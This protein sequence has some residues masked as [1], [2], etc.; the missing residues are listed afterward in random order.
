MS[1]SIDERIVE[2]RFQ[3][4][5]FERGI[6]Q[7]TESL[8]N[9]KDSLNF[10]DS[11]AGT[12]K[13]GQAF[14]DLA[15]VNVPAL[16]S[17]LE[18]AGKGFSAL[19]TMAVSSLATIASRVTDAAMNVAKGL[20]IDQI[21]AGFSKYE[22]TIR[23]TK[24]IMAATGKEAEE[25]GQKLQKLT[26]FTDE[27]S[28]NMSDM[29]DNI[30]KFTSAG[31]DLD[32]SVDSMMGIANWAAV[33]GQNA[34][35]ASRAMY[36]MSQAIG[37]GK[38]QLID[39]RS[40]ENAS[41]NTQEFMQTAIDTAVELGKLKKVNDKVMTSDKKLAVTT[42]SFSETLKKGWFTTDVM[43]ATLRK[44]S[45]YTNEVYELCQKEGISASEA[46]D[47]L[48]DSTD[49][50]GKKSFEAGQQSRTFA[51]SIDATKDAVSTQWMQT[52]EYIFGN[53]DEAVALWTKVTDILWKVF[54][55]GGEVRNELLEIWHDDGGRASL[56]NAFS[57]LYDI[58]SAV[59]D[60]ADRAFKDIIPPITGERLIELT[61]GFE[62]FT[63]RVKT[64][65]GFVDDFKEAVDDAIDAIT[66]ADAGISE[67]GALSTSAK[68]DVEKAQEI[69]KTMPEWM[70][71]WASKETG[72][73]LPV[74][75]GWQESVN[76]DKW[77]EYQAAKLGIPVDLIK[78]QYEAY[79]KLNSTAKNRL[80][81]GKD[82]SWADGKTW[83]E[84]YTKAWNEY[85]DAAEA[86]EAAIN[87][88]VEA[89]NAAAESLEK[90]GDAAE[91]SS[92]SAYKSLTIYEKLTKIVHGFAAAV[93]IVKTT[94][95]RLANGVLKLL[96]ALKPLGDVFTDILA[97]IGDWLVKQDEAVKKSDKLTRIIDGAVSFFKPLI[98]DLADAIRFL[99][100]SFKGIRGAVKASGLLD[101][102]GQKI[103]VVW[104]AVKEFALEIRNS[105]GWGIADFIGEFANR[106]V[107]A[108]KSFFTID[109]SEFAGLKEKLLKRL[110]PLFDVGD[111]LKTLI[112]FNKDSDE[113]DTVSGADG[114]VTYL[115]RIKNFFSNLLSPIVNF[116]STDTS[117]LDTLE[118]KLGKRFEALG[119]IGKWLSEFITGDTWK[120]IKEGF[121]SAIQE[122][123]GFFKTLNFPKSKESESDLLTK[124]VD[125]LIP[126][127][128]AEEDIESV[129]EADEGAF[130]LSSALDNAGSFFEALGKSILGILKRLADFV[131]PA[132]QSALE[133]G[134]NIIKLLKGFI[135]AKALL[136]MASAANNISKTVK[137]LA[138]VKKAENTDSIGTTFLKIAG[139]L[140]IVAGTIALLALIPND[141][142]V[143]GG[144]VAV[145]IAAALLGIS[146]AFGALSNKFDG[147]SSAGDQFIKMASALIIVAAAIMALALIP[148]NMYGEAL[149]KMGLVFIWL[150]G[151]S[152]LLKK[153][154]GGTLSETNGL[155]GLAL[156]IL[157]LAGAIIVLGSI[158]W[159][160]AIRG[161]A[162]LGLILI[163]LVTTIHFI[164][165]SNL[166][167]SGWVFIGLAA[168]ILMLVGAVVILGGMDLISL[169]KGVVA[170]GGIFVGLGACFKLMSKT[171]MT[172]ALPSI[173]AMAAV[174][175]LFT[176]S[177]KQIK[178]VPWTTIAAFSAGM[179]AICL[180]F[181]GAITIL[182]GIPFTAGIKAAGLLA[183]FI[184]AISAAFAVGLNL[185]ASS[186]SD[187]I[188]KLSSALEL[189]GGMI[190]GF[191]SAI[192]G[193]SSERVIELKSIFDVLV[194][195][196][197]SIP[198]SSNGTNIIAFSGYLGQLG[199]ALN[200][201]IANS[202]DATI[203]SVSAR[204][205][206]L[207][208]LIGVLT[209]ISSSDFSNVGT[210]SSQLTTLGG[211]LKIFA[212][213]DSGLSGKEA[214]TR[215]EDA[216]ALLST[217]IENLPDDLGSTISS[218]P[219]ESTL[220]TFSAQ[221]VALGG[222]LLD[223]SNSVSDVN[224]DK[225]DN[226][227][228]SLGLLNELDNNLK[229][230]G[231]VIEQ[232][233]GISSL[234]T[235]STSVAD[236]GG[237]LA[238]FA[239]ETKDIDGN[240]VKNA[241][242]SLSMLNELD[243]GLT[244]H[245]G[246]L[247]FF[248]GKASLSTFS[249]D[250]NA[251]GEGLRNFS[252]KT[253]DIDAAKVTAAANALSILGTVDS[254][255]TEHG[256]LK[257]L[258][259]GDQTL[260]DLGGSLD[261]VG[262]GL[263][264]FCTALKDV[265]NTDV[266]EKA[267]LIL[268]DLAI[269][270]T[271]LNTASSIYNLKAFADS[272]HKSNTEGIGIQLKEFAS[273]LVGFNSENVTGAVD[274]L[275]SLSSIDSNSLVALGKTF[276]DG[277]ISSSTM[278]DIKTGISTL[279]S[280]MVSE[281][282][283]YYDEFYSAGDYLA[284]G[285]AIG[286]SANAWRV[287]N[288]AA[289][290]ARK[291]VTA[292]RNTLDINSPSRVGE[293]I[294]MYWDMGVA[295]GMANYSALIEDAAKESSETAVR[296]AAGIVA[297]VSSVMAQDLDSAPTITPVLDMSNVQAGLTG[298]DGM[299]GARTLNVSGVN[300]TGLLSR[301]N[302]AVPNQNGSDYGTIVNAIMSVN[303][304]INELGE[305]LSKMQV[306]LNSGALVGQIAG[307][308]DRTL[309]ERTM[310]KGR[311][312]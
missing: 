14:D 92:E 200:L 199:S 78:K 26:W 7:S 189:T 101:I 41:M 237:G 249:T 165:S 252:N 40:I 216:T 288:A 274:V 287:V 156:G 82:R 94:L 36:N 240:K 263:A 232:I 102:L 220:S 210:F 126:K 211:A 203:E 266:A 104:N 194:G 124:F 96:P 142:L 134:T 238:T 54:A 52:F 298:F 310:L 214:A 306:V 197:A 226:A 184:V 272:L 185:V 139:A 293:E 109:T 292:T 223:F 294:G 278:T 62:A 231:G 10:D 307:D 28:Y 64:A 116:F 49:T 38:M 166:G 68:A 35:S 71:K 80:R 17:A 100:E 147:M 247:E 46:M 76:F 44:Y 204:V 193:V 208:D 91:D 119:L 33:S 255:L 90:T 172:K 235:F 264:S 113:L 129:E 150:A 153:V 308:M 187:A 303:G 29:T 213:A 245:G 174:M 270:D 88:T 48:S 43:L 97:E 190:S 284:A 149:I 9:L 281:I 244:L 271:N 95:G 51:D 81:E 6:K 112:G 164:E 23:S 296:S 73:N 103:S 243:S 257:G 110:E 260:G 53:I 16:N 118:E 195:I 144:F 50:L 179:S 133:I 302:E 61:K 160:V 248:T 171:N 30:A 202:A 39:W 299:F 127:A 178:D 159:E 286:I 282:K 130:S 207:E 37:A 15:A 206:S 2:M 56:L 234:D 285:I 58:I 111:W 305:R 57:N 31:V 106:F 25:V 75:R 219:A 311:G 55:S 277:I 169:T 70:K 251:V 265:T 218:I 67:D 125:F 312:N 227:I 85:W 157:I 246:I 146:T 225:V 279:L 177:I 105:G 8:K 4:D 69:Y 22:T 148:W 131:I 155:T 122:I 289:Y 27:T 117:E 239:D 167:K 135:L 123:K 107:E 66:G 198:A 42:S 300:T 11:A 175:V 259:M 3:N 183:I 280:S 87:G 83:S 192:D 152:A 236:L 267:A 276:K 24:T 283:G 74:I 121:S 188:V 228:E 136:S 1:Q 224:Q 145:C 137:T 132:M 84:G 173:L 229:N 89:A 301:A 60:I 108:I 273:D 65:L 115:D 128:L 99:W 254:T 19:E 262:T 143:K 221:L 176:E 275:N 196:V 163:G 151:F 230:H 168:A 170:L 79:N 191:V 241:I 180:A 304:R 269:A 182:S 161:I 45:N 93:N 120:T 77:S 253:K 181:A 32:T 21:S 140:L 12:K 215:V 290:I 86:V 20:S 63:E 186:L 34:T 162:F 47:R 233:I 291:A 242:G 158:K 205:T 297:K 309:G 217:L 201:F 138:K 154:N 59:A 209:T 256:G 258:I 13:L 114:S 295:G 212:G 98:Q 18:T 5:Q 222:A 141:M 268:Q 72:V 250:I 261:T